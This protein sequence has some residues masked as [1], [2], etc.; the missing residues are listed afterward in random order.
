MEP[1]QIVCIDQDELR[2]YAEVIQMVPERQRC[3]A[4]PLALGQ[5]DA[6]SDQLE[7]L[8][9][10]RE[11]SQLVLPAQLFRP[12]L[13]T[14]VLPLLTELWQ[15]EKQQV[16]PSTDTEFLNSQALHHFVRALPLAEQ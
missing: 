9:D 6:E 14:E 3:W 4:R 5:V 8:H 1:Q 11:A 7:L 10:L 15:R 16:S 12:A 2:L 13:D